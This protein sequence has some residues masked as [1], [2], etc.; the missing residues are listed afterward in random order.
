MS[1]TMISIAGSAGDFT[2]YLA[3][4]G[5]TG[6]GPGVLVCQ[7]IFGVNTEMRRVCDWLAREGFVA[8]CP[9]LFHR[10]EPGLSLTDASDEEWQ[11]AFE[12]YQGFDLDAGV[13][14]MSAALSALRGHEAC[15][16]KAGA[17]GYCLGGLLAYLAATRTDSDASVGYY[18]VSIP[19]YLAEAN[20]IS[21]PLMLHIAG[22]DEYVPADAQSAIKEMLTNH[23]DATLHVYDGRDHAF[24]RDGGAHFDAD[25][26]AL[27]NTRTLDFLRAHLT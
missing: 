18:G 15:S 7:E 20:K 23:P 8:L 5:V 11:R 21:A 25:D 9:D 27:A 2:G 1:G 13:R 4:P 3:R 17:V 14:D 24:A 16:G 12:L 22:Q 6:T 26:A 19:D 10:Q